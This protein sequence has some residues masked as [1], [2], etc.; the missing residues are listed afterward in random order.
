MLYVYVFVVAQKFLSKRNSK[1]NEVN[2][3]LQIIMYTTQYYILRLQ[4]YLTN[5]TGVVCSITYICFTIN[6]PS[7]QFLDSDFAKFLKIVVRGQ[8]CLLM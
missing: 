3:L 4:T 5:N 8:G 7:H 6:P 2:I 1:P